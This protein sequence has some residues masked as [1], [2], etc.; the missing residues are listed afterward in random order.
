MK[1]LAYVA[2]LIGFAIPAASHATQAGPGFISNPAP[3]SAGGYSFNMLDATGHLIVRSGL[4]SCAASQPS[5]WALDTTNL[6]G[7]IQAEAVLDAYRHHDSVTIIGDGAC[8][9][10][11][12]TESAVTV[13]FN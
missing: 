13:N 4:P 8:T 9:I 7:A 10:L 2:V 5:L 6:S 1:R 12:N 11:P 3:T